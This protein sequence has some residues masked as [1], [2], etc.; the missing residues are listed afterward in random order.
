MTCVTLLF[1][2]SGAAGL[3]FEIVWFHRCGLVFG[4]SVWSTS[5][6]LSSFMGGLALGSVVVGR[7]GARAATLRTYAVLEAAV[8]LAGIAL[9]Y[10]LPALTPLVAALAA[11]FAEQ[12]WLVNLIR[13]AG[14]FAVL[15]VP[16][17][18][19]GATL[20]VLVGAATGG[21]RDFRRALGR[22]YG[23]NTLGAVV[24]VV[25]AELI[26]IDRLGV[27]GT[28]WTAAGL[29]LA[30]SAGAF[31]LS[32]GRVDASVA[33]AGLAE[34]RLHVPSTPRPALL[35]AAFLAG[36]NLL[37][38]EVIWFR[39]LTMYVLA[40]TVAASVMLAAVLS[41]IGLGGL[42]SRRLFG[43]SSP[44]AHAPVVALA[45]GCATAVSYVAFQWLTR[46]TQ[47][48]AWY[49]VLWFACVLTV[50][51]AF[52]SGVLFTLLGA[53]IERDAG[54]PTRSAASLTVANTAGAMCGP[55]AAA[56]VMLPALGMERSF[57]AAAAS[58]AVV[59]LLTLR[60]SGGIAARARSPLFVAAAMAFVASLLLFPFGLMRGIYFTRSAQAYA[61]DGSDIVATREGP[62]ETIFLMHQTWLNQPVYSRLVTNGFSM[63]GTAVPAMRYMRYFAYWPMLLHQAPLR[64]ALVICYGAGVT[65]GAALDIPTLES[66]DVVELSREI[67]AT[68]DLIYTPER[69]PLH[70]PRVRLYVEDGR[71][72]LQASHGR[73]DLITG[74]PPP[75]RTPGAVNIYTREYFGLIRDR[76]AEGGI[77][78]YW[79]PV[80]R[81]DPGTDVHTIVRAFCDVFDDCSLWNATPFDLMLAG[82]RRATGPIS[83]AAFSGAWQ[84]PRLAARLHEIGFEQPEQIGATF[85]GDA[86]YLREL[87]AGTPPLTDDFPQRLR[88]ASDRPSLS[89]P[90]YRSDSS[91]MALYQQVIDTDRARRAFGSSDFVRRLWPPALI[92]ATLPFFDEQ[93]VLNRVLLEGGGPLRQIEDLQALLTTTT[94]RTLPLWVL[95]TDD[96]KQRIAEES[97]ERT[98]ATEYALGLRALTTREYMRAAAH[99][100]EA[101]R[102]GLQSPTI[103]PLLVYA[104]CLAGDRNAARQLARGAGARDADE[105]RFWS[106]MKAE[107]GIE[108]DQPAAE[109]DT[110]ASR[111]TR[112]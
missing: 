58:Y 78:T 34:A 48:G 62:S 36:A 100:S 14:A 86:A 29:D 103:R 55:L 108:P 15:L 85:L 30:V 59:C 38:L 28:A 12:V 23:W 49:S 74:E 112:R 8:A 93:R 109:T 68:S 73:F 64:R 4:N 94:L 54:T 65:A 2:V 107:F 27:L 96:V 83:P 9:A 39:F 16:A 26:L 44:D 106:W 35:A 7:L 5:L 97:A 66:L 111:P 1:F 20:P 61:G 89:D 46:G 69:H 24:G 51:T 45:A 3:M 52:L 99:F 67:V 87:T 13:L 80:A 37:L 98:G 11:P 43:A 77:A 102:R 6:V 25:S 72:F 91:V 33:S 41:A 81:P 50:P 90:R 82:T 79:L 56:F 19:M 71:Y 75:P 95:G 22:L 10:G 101:E 53:A 57:F 18:A 31:A 92:D 47:V 63:T 70:D 104:L 60:G 84:Q 110:N 17:M 105:R 42:A 76:L 32:R 40:T 88:P 21:D